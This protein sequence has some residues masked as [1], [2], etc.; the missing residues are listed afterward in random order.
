MN[1]VDR[2]F[3]RERNLQDCP[4]KVWQDVITAVEDACNAFSKVKDDPSVHIRRENGDAIVVRIEFP[5]HPYPGVP[6]GVAVINDVRIAFD[7]PLLLI[8]ATLNEKT[9]KEFPLGS[10]EV[11]CFLTYQSSRI[12]ADKLSEIALKD[13]LEKAPVP[14]TPQRYGH[15]PRSG[16]WS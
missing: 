5:R 4:R 13:A 6:G 11:E 7:E 8:T 16:A 10:D 2:Q 9:P 15:N 3:A 14:Q 12:D 1:W